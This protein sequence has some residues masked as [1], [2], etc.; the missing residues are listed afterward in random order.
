MECTFIDINENEFLKQGEELLRILLKDN[1]TGKNI[2]WA[3]GNYSS[4]GESYSFGAEI[5][6]GLITGL[7]SSIIKPRVKK[8]KEE[9]QKRAKQNAEVFT[10]SWICN[11]MN[12]LLDK[13]WFDEKL[14]FNTEIETAEERGW[15]TNPK[16]IPFP[17]TDGRT[18]QDYVESTR[19]EITCGEA[20]FLASRY[21]AVNGEYIAVQDRIGILDRKLR[22]V[23]ENTESRD[24]WLKWATAATQSVYGYDWQGDN[25]LLARENILFTVI[26]HFEDKFGEKLSDEEITAFAKIIAWNIWQM[27]GLRFVIPNSCST[28][29]VY[30]EDLFERRLISKPCPGCA[31]KKD[32]IKYAKMHNGIYCMVMDWKENKTLR[33]VDLLRYENGEAKK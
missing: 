9:Q 30:E 33:F 12:N 14:V 6:T 7:N 22:V 13:S 32:Y 2:I 21:D 27:D 3:T 16:R 11:A 10:P 23:S 24:E 1:T 17:T 25:V 15:K 18:W 28:I 31:K 19:L 29:E 26:E 4:L 8:A 20:P 5:K